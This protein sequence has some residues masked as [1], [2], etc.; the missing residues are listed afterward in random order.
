MSI[1]VND[2]KSLTLSFMNKTKAL[3]EA[4]TDKHHRICDSFLQ[5]MPRTVCVSVIHELSSLL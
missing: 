5:I 2:I 3:E 1:V 4:A